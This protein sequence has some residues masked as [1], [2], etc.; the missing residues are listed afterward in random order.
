MQC[1]LEDLAWDNKKLQAHLQMAIKEHHFLES[2]LSELEEDHDKA[3]LKI[4]LMEKEVR[5][6]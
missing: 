1:Q 4:E 6:S 2:M 5:T 3:I